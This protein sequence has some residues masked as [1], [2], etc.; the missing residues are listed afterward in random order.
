M[1]LRDRLEADEDE[2]LAPWASRSRDSLGRLFDEA[3]HD[4]RTAFQRDRDRVLHSSAF[5][6]LQYKTQVFVYR[7]GDH[8][9]SRLTHTLEVAQIGRTL[10]RALGANEDLTEGGRWRVPSVPTRT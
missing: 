1:P 9:R 7:E 5:R 2:R 8:F 3:E 4:Y 6:R 10:A